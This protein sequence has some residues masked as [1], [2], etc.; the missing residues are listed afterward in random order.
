MFIM[1]FCL[2]FNFININNISV[3]IIGFVG[4]FGGILYIFGF[5]IINVIFNKI[6]IVLFVIFF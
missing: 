3:N 5:V 6:F 1:G 2:N 4:L